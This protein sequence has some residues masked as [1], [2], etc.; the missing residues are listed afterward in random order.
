MYDYPQTT[1]YLFE[2]VPLDDDTVSKGFIG[3]PGAY[4]FIREFLVMNDGSIASNALV[5]GLGDGTTDD[6]YARLN[7]DALTAGHSGVADADDF[8]AR[9]IEP[10]AEVF[11][12]IIT[13]QTA[14]AGGHVQVVVQWSDNRPPHGV[15][16]DGN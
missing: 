10:D 12:N 16:L 7:I 1:T 14:N 11:M 8:T 4:G 5:F 13:D 6:A 15:G 9:I 3:P 2:S